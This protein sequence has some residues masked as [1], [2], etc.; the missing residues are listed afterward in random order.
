MYINNDIR[1]IKNELRIQSKNIRRNLNKNK[2]LSMDYAI[3]NKFLSLNIYNRENILFTYLSKEIEVDTFNII[4]SA[5]LSNKKIAVP[6]CITE[7]CDMEF[8]FI[9]SLSDLA[10]GAFNVLEPIP[11]KCEIVKDFS[12]GICIVPG[13][14]FDSQGFRLGYGKGYYDRFLSRFKG[15]TVGLCYSCCTHLKFPHGKYDK[16]VNILITDKYIRQN[17]IKRKSYKGVSSIN[18]KL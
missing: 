1:N 3:H 12:R 11:S 9:E 14:C 16:Q 17:I 5:R 13:L 2:K 6:K 7:T 18:E 10:P 15:I 8:Y 4:K